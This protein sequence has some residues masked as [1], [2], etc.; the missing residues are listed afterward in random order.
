MRLLRCISM[1][2]FLVVVLSLGCSLPSKPQSPK[3]PKWDAE[4][5]IPLADYTYEFSELEEIDSDSTL[6]AD[7]GGLFHIT[8]KD[9]LD[10]F[11]VGTELKLDPPAPKTF[12]QSIGDISID[13][14]GSQESPMITFNELTQGKFSAFQGVELDSIP[15]FELVKIEKDLP[16]F[17]DF[18][19]ATVKEGTLELTVRNNT[20]I[21]L[22]NPV[23]VTVESRRRDIPFR[24]LIEF[25]DPIPP[26]GEQTKLIDLAG[27]TL[28]N[29][30]RVALEGNS[31]GSNGKPVVVDV[32]SYI[33]V[34]VSISGLKVLQARAKIPR[35]HFQMSSA[36]A[37]DEKIEVMEA[38][39][40]SGG[41]TIDLSSQLPVDANVTV[42][43]PAL[44]RQGKPLRK[45]FEL[46][47]NRPRQLEYIDLSDYRIA[48]PKPG[49]PL[50]SLNYHLDVVTID[51]RW[52]SDPDPFATI[53]S[54]N[55]V[56]ATV[57]LDTLKFSHLKGNIVEEQD[58]E[59]PE[60]RQGISLEDLPKGLEPDWIAFKEANFLVKTK[61]VDTPVTLDL[62]IVGERFDEDG[63]LEE[64]REKRQIITISKQSPDFLIEAGEIISIMPDSLEI[65]GTATIQG[66]VDITDES[67][68]EGTVE[69]DAP[70]IFRVKHS[71][72]QV[73]EVSEEEI[74][75]DIREAFE[76]NDVKNIRLLG[77]I[78]NHNPLSGEVLLLASA[79]ST[80]FS[81]AALAETDTLLSLRLPQPTFSADGSI[82]EPGYGPISVEL[83]TTEFDLFKN[84]VVYVKTQV[85]LDSTETEQNRQGWV[86]LRNTD[87]IHV[88]ARAEIE[89]K[90]D[91]E[92]LTKEESD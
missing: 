14:P 45:Y 26:R 31:L 75:Q 59:I 46:R 32:N 69:M 20:I 84:P 8:Y 92:R 48:N 73:G 87:Y 7:E 82:S 15:S 57:S 85:I 5:A 38:A 72:M 74:G 42:E 58:F 65:S 19:S 41:I 60:T 76:N 54:D 3:A 33:T 35:Q 34:E 53:S 50:D 68:V 13:S 86:S 28:A 21:Y 80:A 43:I 77:E 44:T 63:V 49:T 18:E 51:T 4:F 56:V 90:V 25:K 89:L 16:A 23:K 29:Q 47:T 67:Y 88:K 78:E 70:L 83:D 66:E 11:N 55:F 79:D 2:G 36:S 61:G 91:L 39:I 1:S 12:S 37:L 52:D 27:L 17:G 62:L 81:S 24:Q 9:T 6:F 64:R 40:K 30:M 22:G 71:V 10:R